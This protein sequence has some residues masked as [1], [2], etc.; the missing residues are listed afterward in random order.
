MISVSTP[1]MKMNLP[2]KVSSAGLEQKKT[3]NTPISSL[4]RDIPR[5]SPLIFNPNGHSSSVVIKNSK[6]II[7]VLSSTTESRNISVSREKYLKA[8]LVTEDSPH[9]LR[10]TP[11]KVTRSPIIQFSAEQPA[12]LALPKLIFD[13]TKTS[14]NGSTS[15]SLVLPQDRRQGPRSRL[16]NI[17]DEDDQYLDDMIEH[18]G[19]RNSNLQTPLSGAKLNMF[20]IV[21]KSVQKPTKSAKMPASMNLDK[22][23]LSTAQPYGEKKAV[24][25]KNILTPN[26][27]LEEELAKPTSLPN[28]YMDELG[29]L[30]T[31][32]RSGGVADSIESE[33]LKSFYEHFCSSLQT[34][35]GM[36]NDT[37]ADSKEFLK[38]LEMRHQL[39]IAEKDISPQTSQLDKPLLVLDLDETLIHK[40]VQ[41]RIYREDA[42]LLELK[43]F[44]PKD[45]HGRF[46]TVYKRPYLQEFLQGLAEHYTI[47]VF[48]ASDQRY[49]TAIV[50]AIDPERQYISRVFD[51]RFCCATLDGYLVKDLRIFSR[52]APLNK[53]LL[54]DNSSHCFFTQLKN[55]IPILSFYDQKEDGE[56][57]HLKR[58]LLALCRCEN[59]LVRNEEHFLFDKY[60]TVGRADYLVQKIANPK[61]IL[62]RLKKQF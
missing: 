50:N 6:P 42:Q 18:F 34:L 5:I 12:K 33:F 28:Y 37:L 22:S 8:A 58:Y 39:R 41:G 56:L 29:Q 14:S 19:A 38:K 17:F 36:S 24:S 43:C 30:A 27:S 44:V 15:D 46:F 7:N 45:P 23:S 13:T 1:I 20:R 55:G 9:R 2:I 51:R 10:N 49:A 26:D 11:L 32:F 47:Y 31:H 35:R 53:I 40:P 54:V 57:L 25:S 21:N 59:M 3:L 62:A 4:S 16:S 60:F 48:T 52:D 61:L